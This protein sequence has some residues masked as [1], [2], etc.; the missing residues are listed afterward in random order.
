[1]WLPLRTRERNLLE[2]LQIVHKSAAKERENFGNMAYSLQQ[3]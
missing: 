3:A 1:L 2:L